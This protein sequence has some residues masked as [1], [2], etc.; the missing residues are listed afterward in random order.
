MRAGGRGEPAGDV[1]GAWTQ[2][3]AVVLGE[4]LG[5]VG[6]HVD[7]RGAVGLAA[8]ARQAQVQGV[9]DLFGAPAVGDGAVTVAVE[10]LEQQPGAAA[11]G[12]LF[13][14]GDLVGGTHH[15]AALVVVLAALADPDAPVR[16]LPERAAV[17][18]VGEE[19]RP[20]LLRRP[21]AAEPQVLIEPG[22]IHDLAGVHLVGRVEQR[23]DVL[24]QGDDVG[25]EH[26]RQQFAAGLPV[27]VLPGQ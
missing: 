6:G 16:G 21:A 22:G 19:Q 15:G 5:L 20:V 9:L 17:V 12:V 14:A 10:H 11:G 1:V 26:A 18:G 24:E 4:E 13:L 3:V 27:A 7:V 2:P 23:L 8:L 25:A